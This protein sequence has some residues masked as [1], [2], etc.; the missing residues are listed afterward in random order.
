MFRRHSKQLR[1][2]SDLPHHSVLH[3][4]AVEPRKN[5][6]GKTVM[7]YFQAHLYSP[8]TGSMKNIWLAFHPDTVEH[9]HTMLWGYPSVVSYIRLERG[10]DD[11]RHI[12]KTR[13][14]IC[15]NT[16]ANLLAEQLKLTKDEAVQQGNGM[17]L[18]QF[19]SDQR[20]NVV[21][22]KRDPVTRRQTPMILCMFEVNG[23]EFYCDLSI[24]MNNL[25]EIAQ[26]PLGWGSVRRVDGEHKVIIDPA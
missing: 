23:H 15:G 9:D 8:V 21:G 7:Y 22:I 17:C 2:P 13:L 20:I 18:C 12:F 26:S 25:R 10:N 19:P 11:S 4:E 6:R 16:I 3:I 24:S 14:A 5:R 1:F